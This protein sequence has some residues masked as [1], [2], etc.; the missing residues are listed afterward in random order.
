VTRLCVFDC[1]GTLVD[2]GQSICDAMDLAFAR[3][4]LAAPAHAATRRIVGLSLVEAMG[5]LLPDAAPALHAR[6]AHGYREAFTVVRGRPGFAEPL[7][8][9]ALDALA[10]IEGAG[11]ALAIC[12]GKSDR[13]LARVLESH[14]IH[15]R[16]PI[17][18]TADRHPSKPH[19]SMLE[20]AIAEAGADHAVMIGDTVFDMAMAAAA[21][22]D[23]V[24]VAWGYHTPDELRRAGARAIAPDFARLPGLLEDIPA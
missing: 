10:A 11:W 16:F 12:T 18:H 24:G 3:E 17:R 23:R 4:G 8:E 5:V 7:F 19:P 15:A 2:S 22:C 1:D 9:G 6:L 14:D 13:G 21:G 20:A